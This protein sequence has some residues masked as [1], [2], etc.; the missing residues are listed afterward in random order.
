MT[1][2]VNM[3]D[4][5]HVRNVMRVYGGSLHWLRLAK[6]AIH[7]MFEHG[8]IGQDEAREM[9]VEAGSRINMQLGKMRAAP[10][11]GMRSIGAR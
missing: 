3:L 6:M 11:R 10:G 5:I 4:P 2:G 8:I 7:A 1:R 9:R